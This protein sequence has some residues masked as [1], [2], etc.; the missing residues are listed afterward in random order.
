[1]IKLVMA[2]HVELMNSDEEIE[3]RENLILGRNG[4]RREMIQK[5]S[6]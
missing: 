2:M 6:L 5:Q 4:M 3:T 1:M